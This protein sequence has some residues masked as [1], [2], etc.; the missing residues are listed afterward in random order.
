VGLVKSPKKIIGK[1]SRKLVCLHHQ[2][3][4][5]HVCIISNKADASVSI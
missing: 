2:Q 1:T 4:N 3:Q 5:W